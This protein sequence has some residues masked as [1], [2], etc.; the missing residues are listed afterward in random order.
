MKHQRQ[1]Y[2]GTRQQPVINHQPYS[3]HHTQ[4]TRGIQ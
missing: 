4:H 1:Q 2:T 3:V